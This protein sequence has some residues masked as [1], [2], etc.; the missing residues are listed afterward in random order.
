[1]TDHDMNKENNTEKNHKTILVAEDEQDFVKVYQLKLS[2]EGFNIIVAHNGEEA[3]NL[4]KA[5]KPDLILLDLIM[6]VKDGFQ[7]LKELKS[8]EKLKHIKVVVFSNLGQED[9]EVKAK[10]LG[11][12]DYF[13]KSNI[14]IYEMVEKVKSFLK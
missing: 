9:D 13:I 6:P 2:Q 12:S 1:M 11:A 8:D 10:A 5:N 4:A 7:V 14:S 3:V